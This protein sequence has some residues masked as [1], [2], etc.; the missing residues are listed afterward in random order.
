[1]GDLGKYGR[2]ELLRRWLGVTFWVH[3]KL[4]ALF[5]LLGQTSARRPWAVMAGAVA[6]AF[7]AGS[8]CATH[9]KYR[10]DF[11]LWVPRH[12]EAKLAELRYEELWPPEAELGYYIIGA[13]K[14]GGGSILEPEVLAAAMDL[15]NEARERA[16]AARRACAAAAAVAGTRPKRAVDEGGPLTRDAPA[17][18]I[19]RARA[20]LFRRSARSAS[21]RRTGARSGSSTRATTRRPYSRACASSARACLRGRTRARRARVSRR[22][23]ASRAAARARTR[24]TRLRSSPTRRACSRA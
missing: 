13:R 17:T 10:A 20:R 7:V 1:M 22:A 5:E 14:R 18:P 9:W 24:S 6:V 12:S 19:S 16:T 23:A 21:R 3:R 4:E 11:L 15:Y 8:G 2:A